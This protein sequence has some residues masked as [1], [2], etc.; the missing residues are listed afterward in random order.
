MCGICGIVDFNG[1]KVNKESINLMTD[2]MVHR[3]PDD[4]G[5]FTT[6]NIGLGIRRLS[7][8]D[9]DTGHQPISNEDNSIWVVLNGEIYNYVEIRQDLEK[10]GHIFKTKSDLEKG[11]KSDVGKSILGKLLN[12]SFGGRGGVG[13][14]STSIT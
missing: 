2:A 13:S 10:R 6:K 11:A 5:C 3:G 9:L 14:G 12:R 7:I 8:I 1:N 4:T